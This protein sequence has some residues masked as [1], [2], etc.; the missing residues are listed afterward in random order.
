MKL[1]STS[2]PQDTMTT[3]SHIHHTDFHKASSCEYKWNRRVVELLVYKKKH[4]DCNVPKTFP[5]HK[6]LGLWVATQR[7]QFRMR[8]QG[9]HSQLTD[10][11]VDKLVSIGFQWKVR[12][13]GSQVWKKRCQA[14]IAYRDDH[15]N[16]KV[17]QKYAEDR[18][19][20]SWVNDQR[21]QYKYKTEGKRSTLTDARV[22]ELESIGFV[23]K[24]REI[25]CVPWEHQIREL[26]EYR[27]KHGDCKVP[28][29]YAPNRALA[30]WVANQRTQ[31]KLRQEGKYSPMTDDRIKELESIGFVWRCRDYQ[32]GKCRAASP[33]C[34]SRDDSPT[35]MS[36]RSHGQWC[37]VQ[38]GTAGRRL[39]ELRHH[40]NAKSSGEWASIEFDIGE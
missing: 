38:V 20:G 22:K 5:E 40:R 30:H 7:K 28:F 32:H 21:K 26:I 8:Q 27:N 25:E 16:C 14:L 29:H 13:Q 17:P 10:C 11:R 35:K 33:E 3:P 9:R 36:A 6:A 1:S 24:E 34:E 12:E 19:L 4:G 23:W 2:I 31:Y 37:T 39:L 15:G 18:A